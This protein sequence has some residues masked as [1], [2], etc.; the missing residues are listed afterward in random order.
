[1]G[2]TMSLGFPSPFPPSFN[3]SYLSKSP[4][5]VCVRAHNRESI[6]GHGYIA[7]LI[8]SVAFFFHVGFVPGLFLVA[9]P[10]PDVE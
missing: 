8:D 9:P 10:T 6:P 4:I 2:V 7:R 5:V 1:M 3:P